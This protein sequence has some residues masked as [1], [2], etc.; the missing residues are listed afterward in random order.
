MVPCLKQ[1]F[2]DSLGPGL[3]AELVLWGQPEQVLPVIL[4]SADGKV[5]LTLILDIGWWTSPK[6][7]RFQMRYTTL[8]TLQNSVHTFCTVHYDRSKFFFT[9]HSVIS[10]KNRVTNWLQNHCTPFHSKRSLIWRFNVA[11]NNKTYLGLQVQCPI[12]LPDFNQTGISRHIF[13]KSP[14]SNFL[15]M[16]PVEAALIYEE[17]GMG[18]HGGNRLFSRLCER[19]LKHTISP[20]HGTAWLRNRSNCV[21]YWRAVNWQASNTSYA[22]VSN[23][24]CAITTINTV[25]GLTPSNT[26]IYITHKESVRTA[27]RTFIR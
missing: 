3:E 23:Y 1:R 4:L 11:G 6:S 17:A 5:V 26:E 27:Q 13:I 9:S 24:T 15:Q 2:E 25:S 14:I 10:T 12:L 21:L 8:K 18:G 16:C 20:L 19:A 7:E 22:L